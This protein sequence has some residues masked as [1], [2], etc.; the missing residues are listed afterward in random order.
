METKSGYY[1]RF[2]ADPESETEG[3]WCLAND[4]MDAEKK[5]LAS[6]EDAVIISVETEEEVDE[7]RDSKIQ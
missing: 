4:K 5:C 2:K 1:V 3:Y 6:N 7:R